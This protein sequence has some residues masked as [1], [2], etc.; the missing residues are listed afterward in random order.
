MALTSEETQIVALAAASV[1]EEERK[2]I[3]TIE[4]MSADSIAS[5]SGGDNKGALP[6][7]IQPLFWKYSKEWQELSQGLTDHCPGGGPAVASLMERFLAIWTKYLKVKYT[8]DDRSDTKS[9]RGEIAMQNRDYELKNQLKMVAMALQTV[10]W[11]KL[12]TGIWKDVSCIWRDAYSFSCLLSAVVEIETVSDLKERRKRALRCLDLACLMGG[13]SWRHVVSRFISDLVRL[14]N[15]IEANDKDSVES[16]DGSLL[17]SKYKLDMGPEF[18][19]FL[20]PPP[21]LPPGSLGSSS[22]SHPVPRHHVLSLETFA[23]G[24]M[25]PQHPVIISGAM[26]SWPALKNWQ[27]VDYWRRH[28][29]PRMVPVEVGKHYMVEGWGQQLML[30]SEFLDNHLVY[31]QRENVKEE[32][33]RSQ[34]EGQNEEKEGDKSANCVYLAQHDLV[35]QIP[36]LSQDI[37]QPEYCSLGQPVHATNSWI[38]PVGTVTPLHTDPEQNLLCQVV[39]RKYIRL[40]APEQSRA[41]CCA[42][43][44]D[45]HGEERNEEESNYGG[46]NGSSLTMNTSPV[47]VDTHPLLEESTKKKNLESKEAGSG[48]RIEKNKEKSGMEYPM[49]ASAP[50][51]DCILESGEMLY[52]PVRWWHYVKSLSTSASVNFWWRR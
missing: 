26:N 45:A 29:G 1:V 49:Y 22:L 40:Y 14:I 34:S 8:H 13:T 38:G 52:I 19:S 44:E 48:Y 4:C 9:N 15:E 18:S 6:W 3:S 35:A 42:G 20:P 50:F 51:F 32:K 21:P 30:F 23:T 41:L 25:L 27:R 39:G 47:D 7:V 46:G 17:P 36:H 43:C 24:Y 12:H 10:V 2:H 31:K 33:L 28:A 5:S 11:E 37:H 16:S